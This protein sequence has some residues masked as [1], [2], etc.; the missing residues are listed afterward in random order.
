MSNVTRKHQP[1]KFSKYREIH[2]SYIN[3][4]VAK[5]FIGENTVKFSSD[6]DEILLKG[7]IACL[8]QILITVDKTIEIVKGM[9]DHAIIQTVLYE[10]NV[11]IRSHGNIFRY[12]NSHPRNGHPDNHHKHIFDWKLDGQGEGQVIW[13]GESQ[14]PTLGDVIA[15]AEKWYFEN[16][17]ELPGQNYPVLGLYS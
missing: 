14:W 16:Q 17:D 8:G 5:T 13:I 2:D 11:S 9:G 4:F 1:I 10:Y 3:S 15:E 7:E 6:I 12:D